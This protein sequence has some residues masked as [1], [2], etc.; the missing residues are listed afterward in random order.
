MLSCPGAT[1]RGSAARA[2]RAASVCTRFARHAA[3]FRRKAFVD[4]QNDVTAKDIA[5]ALRE[6]FESIEHVKR[7]TTTGMATDQGKTSNMSALGIVADTLKR[8]VPQVGHDYIPHALH[9]GDL[10]RAD[11]RAPRSAL[12]RGAR[13][14]LAR[15]GQRARRAVRGRR[16]VE[17]RARVP[18]GRR[19]PA[20]R[21]AARMPGRARNRRP[22]RRLD[23]RQ[24]R[25]GR[26]RRARIPES[27][28]RQRLL[29]PRA[30]AQPL[31]AHAARGRLRLRRRHRR[32]AS[33]PSASTSPP[34]PAARRACSP[35]WRT[36][37]RR[38]GAI[39][40]CT[41][42]RSPSSTR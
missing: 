7:Y 42:P 19:G 33:R 37:C 35:T 26:P 2:R 41:S 14:A 38:S 16:P 4:F 13:D 18:A 29:T 39:C 36:T 11:R 27:H 24:D 31:R 10:R 12:R 5:L 15:L 17:T 28:V 6:G 20:R 23:A 40:R 30:R 21:G 9:A 22:V 34:R 32:A 3:T 1:S 25:G 8:P